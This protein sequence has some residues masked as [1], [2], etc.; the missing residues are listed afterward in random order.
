MVITNKGIIIEAKENRVTSIV[1]EDVC[2][3][4]ER[5]SKLLNTENGVIWY[6]C[7]SEKAI[8]AI[9]DNSVGM[10]RCKP[11]TFNGGIKD[12]TDT[13]ELMSTLR[14]SWNFKEATENRETTEDGLVRLLINRFVF[15]CKHTVD[16]ADYIVWSDDYVIGERNLTIGHSDVTTHDIIITD[17]IMRH[18][19]ITLEQVVKVSNILFEEGYVLTNASSGYMGIADMADGKDKELSDEAAEKISQALSLKEEIAVVW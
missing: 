9:L 11:L 3:S 6:D 17:A 7:T 8:K 18:A 5:L 19:G 13:I 16:Y 10:K 2:V 4:H 12:Q 14:F 1:Q 15:G